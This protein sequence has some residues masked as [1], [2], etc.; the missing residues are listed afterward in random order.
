MKLG[1]SNGQQF[2]AKIRKLA[3]GKQISP[4]LLM[5]EVVLDE[6]I[7]R[8]SRSSYRDNLILKGGFLIASMLGVDTRSTRDIDTSIK[9]LPVNKQE[10]LKVFTAI[11]AQDN[12][13]DIQLGITKIDEIRVAADYAGFRVHLKAKIF[14]SEVDTKIDVST[15]DTITPRQVAWYHH[16]IFNDQKII[17]MAYNIETIL[18][19]K[20]ETI[21]ARQELNTR[22]KDYY[23]LYLFDKLQLQN[24][25][26]DVL[27][28]AIVATAR[29]R[30][31]ESLLS[32]YA[33]IIG[34]LA[35]SDNLSLLWQKYQA[36]N[37]YARGIEYKKT[38]EAAIDLVERSKL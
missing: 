37:K 10:V 34:R 24:I 35:L 28:S 5:Q 16:T 13:D 3:K 14:A 25:N 21:V 2:K 38:C 30:G 1:F 31:T 36:A 29:L 20:L 12:S 6:V 27:K 26:F 15:G 23:D 22:L 19:E 11:V 33:E 18:A 17:I 8:I 32:G 7:D 4:Q 9:G